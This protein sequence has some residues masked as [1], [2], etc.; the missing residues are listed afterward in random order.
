MDVE[1]EDAKE[2]V[3]PPLDILNL[4]LQNSS[5]KITM[6]LFAQITMSLP[7]TKNTMSQLWGKVSSNAFISSKLFEFMKVTKIAHIQ[8]LDNVGQCGK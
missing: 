8:V 7:M 3:P 1:T 6:I 5:F 4:E 2:W